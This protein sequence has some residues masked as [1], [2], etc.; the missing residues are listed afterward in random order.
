MKKQMQTHLNFYAHLLLAV[1]GRAE[2]Q[3]IFGE[4]EFV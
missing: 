1:S 3:E 2:G 4:E